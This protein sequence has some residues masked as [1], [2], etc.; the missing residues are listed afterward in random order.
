LVLNKAAIGREFPPVTVAVLLEALQKYALAYND[1]NPA[2]FDPSRS[3]GIVAPPMF[4]VTM[5]W[6]AVMSAV[7]DPDTHTDLMRLVH[8]EQDMEFLCPIQSGDEVTSRARIA[9]IESKASG[10]TMDVQVESRRADGTPVMRTR[11]G[12]FIRARGSRA[13]ASAAADAQPQRG[14]PLVSVAQKIDMDQT[15]RYAEASGDRNP[16]HTD[17]GFARMAGLPGIIVHGLCTMA[18]TSKVIIDGP[19]GGAPERLKR[20]SVRFSRPVIPGQTITTRVW[21]AGARAGI[22]TFSFETYNPDGAAVIKDG[23]AEVSD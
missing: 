3:G 8:G 20:L 14:D 2:Y 9:S 7:M 18:F 12:V 13:G 11:F 15:V 17:E 1:P 6:S 5:I 4:G 23:L 21:P 19:C 16:I 10:E 22:R